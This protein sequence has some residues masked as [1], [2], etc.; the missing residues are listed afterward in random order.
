MLPS[1]RMLRYLNEL[2]AKGDKSGDVLQMDVLLREALEGGK[3]TTIKRLATGSSAAQQQSKGET[4]PLHIVWPRKRIGGASSTRAGKVVR[5]AADEV[6]RERLFKVC[7]VW[8]EILEDRSRDSIYRYLKAVYS[9]VMRCE[10]EG[11]ATELLH[12]AII[13][14]DLPVTENPELF[15]TV[16][17]CTCEQRL[18]D[19]LVSKLSR[20]LR[21][22]AYRERPP[23]MLIEFIKGMGGINACASQHAKKLGRGPKENRSET[24]IHQRLS[25]IPLDALVKQRTN[26]V[27]FSEGL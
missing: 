26:V 5:S 25:R 27:G 11:R 1:P 15:S 4:A 12:C 2:T 6:L 7:D 3:P 21:Y 9:A 13:I 23:R 18:D 20:A 22:A 24:G 16:I 8:D 17:R 14:A 19:K 10:R